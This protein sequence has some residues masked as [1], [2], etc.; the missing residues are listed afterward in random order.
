M[1]YWEFPGGYGLTPTGSNGAGIE[2]FLDNIP[3][4]LTREVLQNSIDAHQKDLDTPVRVEFKFETI[5]AKEIL[6]ENE[7]IN[8]IL[9]K[10]ERFWKEK[11]N[12][13]TLHYLETFKSV[14]TSETIDMLV[15][16]DYNTTGLNNQNFASL[17]EGDGYSEKSDETSAGS[18]VLVRPLLLLHL[19]YVLF[20]IIVCLLMM[21]I[22]LQ[23]LSILYL[24]VM[25][26]KSLLMDLLLVIL[27]KHEV[28]YV[29]I[30]RYQRDLLRIDKSMVQTCL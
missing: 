11:N 20:F 18:K 10:A 15:I 4:S 28:V 6:G 27:H 21:E 29:V 14:L 26:R 2:T 3:M 5:Q 9:P 30:S 22:N 8:D 12:A 25:M 23:A 7:L 13:D 19:I 1:K 16:S 17:V 24:I